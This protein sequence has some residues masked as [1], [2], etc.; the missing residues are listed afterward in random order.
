MNN[1][2]V[3]FQTMG[4]IVNEA[5]KIYLAPFQLD[6]SNDIKTIVTKVSVGASQTPKNQKVVANEEVG[7]KIVLL[8][9]LILRSKFR[10]EHRLDLRSI[11]VLSEVS[12]ILL[13]FTEKK[14]VVNKDTFQ[15][16]M[17]QLNKLTLVLSKVDETSMKARY[18]LG[19]RYLRLFILLTLFGSYTNAS[20][21]ATF[22]LEQL[23]VE[24]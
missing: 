23:E 24:A 22:I 4:N 3:V 17:R 16:N 7:R 20:I 18:G 21:V 19:Y 11:P 10:G 5:E 8:A 2:D 6:A 1:Y 9:Y 14:N 15:D 13:I 12:E